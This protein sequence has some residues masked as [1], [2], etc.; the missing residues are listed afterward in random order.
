MGGA[1][2]SLLIKKCGHRQFDISSSHQLYCLIAN[3]SLVFTIWLVECVF[4]ED[5]N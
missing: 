4:K 2:L 3:C 1:K 5:R